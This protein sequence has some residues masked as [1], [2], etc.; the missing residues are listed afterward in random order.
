MK[1]LIFI[2]AACVSTIATLQAQQAQTVTIKESNYLKYLE[3]ISNWG[4]NGNRYTIRKTDITPENLNELKAAK[5]LVLASDLPLDVRD[6]YYNHPNIGGESNVLANLE[7]IVLEE[8]HPIKLLDVR[9][10]LIERATIQNPRSTRTF[11]QLNI[12]SS[13]LKPENITL[14]T[15]SNIALKEIHLHRGLVTSMEPLYGWMKDGVF[16]CLYLNSGRYN[17]YTR[18][19]K[20]NYDVYNP[21]NQIRE[22]DMD[23]IP[24]NITALQLEWNLLEHIEGF[25]SRFNKI[26]NLMLKNNLMW[27]LDLS[28]IS[29]A[30]E[31]MKQYSF[32]P[33]KPMADL[34]VEK[35]VADNGSEDELR[36]YIPAARS[37]AFDK[38]CL[39]GGS[40]KFISRDGKLYELPDQTTFEDA[41]GKYFKL[42]AA[43]T[44]NADLDYYG[45]HDGFTYKYNTRPLLLGDEYAEKRD[46]EV[47]VKVY[48]YIMYINPATKSGSGVDYYSGT[49]WLD[50]HS[51]V[52]EGTTVWIATGIKRDSVDVGSAQAG[53]QLVLEQ[54]GGPG[55]VIPAGTAMYVR[56]K[57]K[58]G[59]YAFQKAWTPEYVG[60]DG[61]FNKETQDALVTDTVMYNENLSRVQAKLDQQI[62]K[63]GNRN[64]LQGSGEETTV[65]AYSTLTLGRES[66]KGTRMIGFWPYTGTKIAAHRCYITD[67]KYKELVEGLT[68]SP[69]AAKGVTFYFEE[70]PETTGIHSIDNGQRTIADDAWYSIDGKRLNAKPTQKGLYIHNGRKEAVL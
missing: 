55:D 49:L 53:N 39:I 46:M 37:A 68:P 27:S 59:L 23:R 30:P 24:S 5:T 62:A 33:Q 66:K 69:G 38:S 34:W 2:L 45:V 16:E 54:I 26:N 56:S 57:T 20:I 61:P 44:I 51:I 32:T 14:G 10:T 8:G 60:W 13:R 19:A 25:D 6:F 42:V 43:D 28:H 50:Y 3:K 63:I 12:Q 67:T 52:P 36:L 7:E 11:D 21:T 40:V 22:I 41:K 65:G 48:P 35:G 70:L 58:A 64:I 9:G 18:S 4:G 29:V 1:R 31:D 17:R 15:G 47:Q